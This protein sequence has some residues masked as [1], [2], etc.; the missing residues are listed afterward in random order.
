MA[1][2]RADTP[3]AIYDTLS[4]D[5]TFTALV[6]D[7]TFDKSST[8]LPALSITS[9]GAPLDPLKHVSGMEVLIHDVSTRTRLKLLD[10][11][12]PTLKT[13]RVYLL[14]WAGADGSTLEAASDRCLELFSDAE[15]I[16]VSS[17]PDGL[18]AT[19]QLLILIPS[20]SVI[21][22]TAPVGPVSDEVA[23]PAATASLT[24]LAPGVDGYTSTMVGVPLAALGLAALL[25]A[26][27]TVNPMSAA[28]SVPP[29]DVAVTALAPEVVGS[30]AAALTFEPG[31]ADYIYKNDNTTIEKSAG[32]TQASVVAGA[33]RTAGK[34]YCEFIVD[35]A[36]S[37][38]WMVGVGT[39]N[40][41]TYLGNFA[42]SLGRDYSSTYFSG[43]GTVTTNTGGFFNPVTGDRFG[44]AVD[45]D[46][47][48]LWIHVNGTYLVGD[49]VAGT[50][51]QAQWTTTGLALK[52]GVRSYFSNGNQ[53]TLPTT[54][55]Y[56][57]SGFQPWTDEVAG[58]APDLAPT[59]LL[60]FDGAD[61]TPLADLQLDSSANAFTPTYSGGYTSTVA[62]KFGGASWR[63]SSVFAYISYDDPLLAPGS[64]DFTFDA[65][66]RRDFI[67]TSN[68]IR[69]LALLFGSMSILQR[70]SAWRLNYN[71]VNYDIVPATVL[72]DDWHHI[73]IVRSGDTLYLFGDG[74]LENTINV[75]G[76]SFTSG[77]IRLDET[78]GNAY[79]D[80]VRYINGAA[81]W[82]ASFTP[83]DAP[84]ADPSLPPLVDVPAIT[85]SVT[86]PAPEVVSGLGPIPATYTQSSVYSTNVAATAEGMTNGVINETSQTGTKEDNPAWLKMDFGSTITFS[87]IVVGPHTSTLSGGW[88]SN[89]SYINNS[90]IEGSNDNSTW[91]TIVASV[92]TFTTTAKTFST[93]GA[94]YRYVRI[95]KAGYLA[96]TE[97]YALS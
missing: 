75:A 29:A 46:N 85:V 16:D 69:R 14:A 61:L 19:S 60:H 68:S 84:Y 86:A 27:E 37:S 1:Q 58:S 2:S 82:T 73:A 7:Y 10:H 63:L 59:L 24:P 3:E 31:N 72:A 39:Q 22:A 6:G 70:E 76:A 77:A 88:G 87:S 74:Q 8:V 18:G 36:T 30:A 91:T 32:S 47:R 11:E 56:T 9:P 40:S 23:I 17:T 12:N 21:A 65:W 83:P 49:P 97:F 15:V 94:S 71:S 53:V 78:V 45:L 33:A 4:G 25:P 96:I 41:T 79:V 57:P 67:E 62:S 20:T 34:W 35:F 50:S 80:E 43:M 44:I 28:V 89:G 38:T 95:Q 90:V 93:P 64:A 13:W 81:A 55:N 52:P 54:F 66:V 51:P 42:S 92:G 26:A 48:K 5:G